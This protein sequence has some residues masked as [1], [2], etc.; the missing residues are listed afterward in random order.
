MVKTAEEGMELPE[1]SMDDYQ[2]YDG[3]ESFHR[4]SGDDLLCWR[5]TSGDK[6][7]EVMHKGEL[8]RVAYDG[9]ML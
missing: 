4:M 8:H 5:D 7:R 3:V 9:W 1:V 2:S 6:W